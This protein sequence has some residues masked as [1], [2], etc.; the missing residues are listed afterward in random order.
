MKFT[1][2]YNGDRKT[3]TAKRTATVLEV[4][5][6]AFPNVSKFDMEKVTVISSKGGR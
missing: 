1:I 6:L 2:E 4:L 5:E 3:I